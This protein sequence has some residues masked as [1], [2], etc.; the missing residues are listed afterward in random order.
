MK[1]GHMPTL[2]LFC[3]SFFPPCFSR[4]KHMNDRKQ[5]VFCSFSLLKDSPQFYASYCI[6]HLPFAVAEMLCVVLFW[7]RHFVATFCVDI[8]CFFIRLLLRTIQ[9]YVLA[10]R[11]QHYVDM[12][13]IGFW[14]HNRLLFHWR[15]TNI[16]SKLL[17]NNTADNIFTYFPYN[18]KQ[19]TALCCE[20]SS[21]NEAEQFLLKYNKDILKR[22]ACI[23]QVYTQ[24][25]RRSQWSTVVVETYWLCIAE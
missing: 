16:N 6:H 10:L 8:V 20:S 2:L 7:K 19:P 17:S 3:T 25:K 22:S 9:I 21:Q 18:S 4:I 11:H 5:M 15:K 14:L 12:T 23:Q 1:F 13:K 24:T